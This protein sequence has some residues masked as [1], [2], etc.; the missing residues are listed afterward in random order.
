MISIGEKKFNK[1]VAA[2]IAGRTAPRGKRMGHAGAIVMGDR[3]T[4]ESKISAFSRVGVPVAKTLSE[5]PS[6]LRGMI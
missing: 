2:L 5:I 3:G 4:T 1:P 6:L